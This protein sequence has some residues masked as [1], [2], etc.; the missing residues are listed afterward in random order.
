MNRLPPMGEM[1]TPDEIEMTLDE[2]LRLLDDRPRVVRWFAAPHGT[3]YPAPEVDGLTFSAPWT[4][5]WVQLNEPSR[6]QLDAVLIVDRADLS[7]RS[8]ALMVLT[9]PTPSAKV[10]WSSSRVDAGPISLG[11]ERAEGPGYRALFPAVYA[12]PPVPGSDHLRFMVPTPPDG[13][14][15]WEVFAVEDGA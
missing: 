14:P 11:C 9:R 15:A 7:S 1:F 8:G 6:D 4:E 10:A 5:P 3:A 12:I 2:E 13:G